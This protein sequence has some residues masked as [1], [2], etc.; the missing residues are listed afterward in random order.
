[1]IEADSFV[2]IINSIVEEG[3]LSADCRRRR[4]TTESGS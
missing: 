3:D 1:M 2:E 4:G